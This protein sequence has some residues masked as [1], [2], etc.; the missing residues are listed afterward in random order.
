MIS[1]EKFL[2]DGYQKLKFSDKTIIDRF[3]KKI[4]KKVNI[5]LKKYNKTI[6]DLE[7]FYKLKLND[8][9]NSFVFDP[10]Y[11]NIEIR[12]NEI[13]EL[14]KSDY[15]KAII[16]HYYGNKKTYI[17]YLVKNKYKTNLSGFRVVQPH[18]S[19][20]ANVHSESSYGHH[21]FTI[22]IPII[23]FS[24]NSTLRIFP[25]SHMYR[26]DDKKI[27]KNRKLNKAQLFK[28]NYVN[29]FKKTKRLNFNKGEFLVFHPDLLH[30]GSLNKSSK[31]RVSMEMRIYQDN[32]VSYKPTKRALKK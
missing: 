29:K 14:Y 11:R 19:K 5:R 25:K 20:V 13:K 31:T 7:K 1:I 4:K 24:K 6:K 22:W 30:G 2:K 12:K 15:L 8:K 18:S 32:K 27:I 21:C 23:G 9:E 16:E 26:H 3:Q 28:K 17:L 10:N